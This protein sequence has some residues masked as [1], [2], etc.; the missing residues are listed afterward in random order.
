MVYRVAGL[1]VRA[2]SQRVSKRKQRNSGKLAIY[3]AVFGVTLVRLVTGLLSDD[4]HW[5]VAAFQ[6]LVLAVLSWVFLAEAR[7]PKAE[8]AGK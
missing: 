1:S 3:A 6:L 2:G 8:L 7:K 4:R 5:G